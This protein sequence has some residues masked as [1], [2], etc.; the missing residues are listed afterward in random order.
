MHVNAVLSGVNLENELPFL[1]KG[2][3]RVLV[4]AWLRLEQIIQIHR[5][6]PAYKSRPK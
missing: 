1:A 5:I 4:F 3:G 6:T 2:S